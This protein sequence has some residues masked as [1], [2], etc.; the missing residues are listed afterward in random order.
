MRDLLGNINPDIQAQTSI[1]YVLGSDYN[2]KL[3]ERPF[4]LTA[5]GYYKEYQNLIPYEIDNVR[6]RYYAKNNAKGYSVGTDLRLYGAFVKGIDSWVSIGVMQTREDLSDDSYTLYYNSEGNEIIQ[7]YTFNNVP[8]DSQKFYPGYIPRP[9]DQRFRFGL[10]FQDYVPKIP[11]MKVNVQ[12]QFATGLPFGPP[13]YER[14]K[15]TLRMPAYRRV[16]MGFSYDLLQAGR[17]KKSTG[18]G[19]FIREAW[20]ALEVFNMFG[21]NNV[22]S[23]LWIRDISNRRYGIPNYLTNRRINLSLHVRF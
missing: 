10:F 20:I 23:Y 4:K 13:S 8:V 17:E 11:A 1:H 18:P 21:I 15:D 12:F 5:E 7:G 16:D 3:W 22:I 6:M 14:Y 19:R 9:T 2:F